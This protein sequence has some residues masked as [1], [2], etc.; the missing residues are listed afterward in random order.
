LDKGLA[1]IFL[2]LEVNETELGFNFFGGSLGG[3]GSG[4]GGGC[5]LGFWCFNVAR[6]D[7]SELRES[8]LE[9]F[10]GY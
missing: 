6:G 5:R 3:R 2:I 4:G 8:T 9:L 10:L 7:F 1:G